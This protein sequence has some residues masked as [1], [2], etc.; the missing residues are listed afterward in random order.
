MLLFFMNDV[1]MASNYVH[2][3]IHWFKFFQVDSNLNSINIYNRFFSLF[4]SRIS[5]YGGQIHVF[6]PN[7]TPIATPS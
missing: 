4:F 3:K 2:V 7:F 6:S 5:W 1:V